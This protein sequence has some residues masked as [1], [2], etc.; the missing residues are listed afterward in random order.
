MVSCVSDKAC[1][2]LLAAEER[3]Q[4]I[5]GKLEQEAESEEATDVV[6]GKPATGMPD[7]AGEAFGNASKESSASVKQGMEGPAGTVTNSEMQ[8]R[9]AASATSSNARQQSAASVASA[10]EPTPTSGACTCT[11][12]G[13]ASLRIICVYNYPPFHHSFIATSIMPCVGRPAWNHVCLSSLRLNGKVRSRIN[14]FLPLWHLLPAQACLAARQL[15]NFC[16]MFLSALC[17]W[18]SAFGLVCLRLLCSSYSQGP[19]GFQI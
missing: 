11:L 19:P 16:Y 1:T 17:L 9:V 12:N 4:D 13:T 10:S 3:E 14:W 6:P 8:G 15:A 5:P 2:V 7:L 18:P